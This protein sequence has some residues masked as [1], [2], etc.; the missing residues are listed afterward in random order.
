MGGDGFDASAK[1]AVGVRGLVWLG[2]NP[3]E[4]GI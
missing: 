1:G 2:E 3:T 4:E